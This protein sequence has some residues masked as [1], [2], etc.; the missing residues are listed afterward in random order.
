MVTV[1]FLVLKVHGSIPLRMC[2]LIKKLSICPTSEGPKQSP[3]K[4]CPLSGL[5]VL[6]CG[7]KRE[8]QPK[9]AGQ[10]TGPMVQLLV[11]PVRSRFNIPSAP[12]LELN[13]TRLWSTVQ[14]ADPV[15]FSKHCMN[16]CFATSYMAT[17]WICW[18]KAST[19]A[20]SYSWKFLKNIDSKSH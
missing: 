1:P 10:F 15:Q 5:G 19:K 7:R 2:L 17:T 20:N 16:L 6:G 12:E 4:V 13:W 8:N 18:R 9:L 11:H 14:P 3:L